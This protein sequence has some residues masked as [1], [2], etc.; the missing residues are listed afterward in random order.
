MG[1][2]NHKD[3]NQESVFWAQGQCVSCSDL[4]SALPEET[5]SAA[6][7]TA[8]AVSLPSPWCWAPGG[9]VLVSQL[10]AAISRSFPPTAWIRPEAASFLGTPAHRSLE[11]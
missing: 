6:V 11:P 1:F 5:A 8:E 4:L 3:I 9:G 10:P 7:L 2:A